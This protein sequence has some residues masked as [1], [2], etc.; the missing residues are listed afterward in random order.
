MMFCLSGARCQVRVRAREVPE[1]GLQGLGARPR[2]TD[3]CGPKVPA[4]AGA[5][6]AL[7]ATR[8]AGIYPGMCMSRAPTLLHVDPEI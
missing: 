1:W 3:A 2:P 6:P 4:H 5:L 7:Q 8:T